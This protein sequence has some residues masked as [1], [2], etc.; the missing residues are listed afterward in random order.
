MYI[1][2]NIKL[3]LLQLLAESKLQSIL[4]TDCISQILDG[5]KL[6]IQTFDFIIWNL[7]VFFHDE[8]FLKVLK[9]SCF[10]RVLQEVHEDNRDAI[11]AGCLTPV[12]L[13]LL[14][15]ADNQVGA[16]STTT[17]HKQ[18]FLFCTRVF[19]PQVLHTLEYFW[20]ITTALLANI[21]KQP[22]H[23][24]TIRLIC[25][26]SKYSFSI[27]HRYQWKFILNII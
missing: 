6:H 16:L 11:L 13:G 21:D 18:S 8:I 14:L 20:S 27:W 3:Q 24:W 10:D 9:F 25:V 1:P 23:P 7:E 4:Q 17:L 22:S 2:I 5:I 15:T 26:S 12:W 19:Y